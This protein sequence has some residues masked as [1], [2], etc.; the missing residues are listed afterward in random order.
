VI[1][2]F[3]IPI[4]E[5]ELELLNR[6]TLSLKRCKREELQEIPQAS[7]VACLDLHCIKY[8]LFVRTPREGDRFTPLGMK[9]TQLISDYLT[10]RKRNRLEKLSALLLCDAQGPL[11]LMNER[12]NQRAVIT[13]LTQEV[14][15]M[16][17]L[18]NAE[19]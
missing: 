3:E 4:A 8:P 15:V 17:W 14:L 5:G 12:P 13:E 1:D 2:S 11:W 9:G 7:N 16:E 19:Y 18:P 6:G 10:N